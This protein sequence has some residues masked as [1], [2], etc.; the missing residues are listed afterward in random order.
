[1]AQE[2]RRVGARRTASLVLVV[3]GTVILFVGG[4][5]LY[6]REEVFDADAFAKHA[7][8]SL[9]DDRVDN[10]VANPI[11]DQVIKVGPDELI[12]ARPLLTAATRGVLAS[13]EFRD[14]FRDAAARVH[15]QL[16]SRERDELILNIA[17]AGA[18]V[19]DGVKSISP[20]TAKKIPKD[21]Q[22]GLI[23]ITRSDFAI[24]TVRTAEKVRFLGLF[25]PFLG[26]AL[27]AGSVAVAPDRRRGVVAASAAVAIACAVGFIALVIGRSVLLSHFDGDVTREAIGA[28]FDNFLGGLR[29]WFIGVGVGAIV[30][31]AAASTVGEV[32]PTAPV[33]RVWE[34][35][36]RTPESTAWRAIRAVVLLLASVFV[37]VSPDLAL[38][39]VAVVLGAYGLFFAMS[40]ILFLI[41]PPPPEAERVPLQKRVRPRAAIIAGGALVALLVLVIVLLVGGDREVKRPGGPVEA[42]NGYPELCDRELNE[43]AFPGAHNAMSA[44]NADFITPNQETKIQDQLDAGIRVLLVDAYYGI[45]RS[46]G[47]VLTDLKREQDRTKVNEALRE[48]FGK[49]AAKRV[50][51]I[52]QRVA[53]SGEEGE[54][55]TYF[56]HIVCELGSIDLT[57][58]LGDVRKFLDTHPDEFLIM[59]I[60]DYI[61]PEDVEKA[62]RDSGLVRYAYVHNRNT[63]FPT[64]RELIES[65]KRILVMAENDNGGGSI[66]WYHDGFELMQETPYTFK[67]ADELRAAASCKP[68]RGTANSPLF[69]L[70][71]WVEKL[72]RSPKLG[73]EVN[74]YDFLI[75]RARECRRRRGLLPNLVAVDFYD[76]GDIF[77]ATRKLNR[78]GRDTEPQVRETG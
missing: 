34:R 19:I 10:A 53:D 6:A 42:C 46:S 68:N 44:A 8:E 70:N 15:R 26:I 28:V 7:S 22:P 58:T 73:A 14:A 36:I 55:S 23:E 35:V 59:V 31:A 5:A 76:E 56:C 27:L 37:V 32:E 29:G 40:E 30:L 39:V 64:L 38:N 51:D 2:V 57:E 13:Q 49:D 74:A 43:V 66:P 45:K 16:F 3:L 62:F 50:Q 72:P 18:I 33:R 54:R 17:D 69:Q 65:D 9:R 60:E 1:M 21:L 63:L 4:I 67:S 61:D 20:Q 41:A 12:N 52:Q 24:T 78:L 25:L 47:P 11:V 75:E 48:Q 77:E 71:H